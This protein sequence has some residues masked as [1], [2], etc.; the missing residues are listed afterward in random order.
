MAT[1]F[2]TLGVYDTLAAYQKAVNAYHRQHGIGIYS[3]Y[4]ARGQYIAATG[5][6]I[7]FHLPLPWR[8]NA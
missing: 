2:V 3:K 4:R 8:T 1:K 6:T 7:L 5:Q